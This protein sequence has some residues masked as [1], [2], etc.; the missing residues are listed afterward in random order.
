MAD[1]GVEFYYVEADKVVLVLVLKIFLNQSITDVVFFH[2]LK[3]V[4]LLIL[5]LI[6]SRM[7][8]LILPISDLVGLINLHVGLLAKF[9]LWSFSVMNASLSVVLS[10]LSSMPS[11]DNITNDERFSVSRF[12]F[13]LK[14]SENKQENK[15]NLK[16]RRS[17]PQVEEL[18]PFED[19][20]LKMV[21]DLKFRPVRNYFQ[22]ELQ[23]N[24]NKIKSSKKFSYRLI[25][26]ETST[27]WI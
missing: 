15:F 7:S 22:T 17:L 13:F 24:L 20:V 16:S 5:L 2:W 19:D 1:G 12:I 6:L 27:A 18:K 23:S 26:R 25:K 21:E 10:T 11:F 9:G 3:L 8:L 14:P 4:V